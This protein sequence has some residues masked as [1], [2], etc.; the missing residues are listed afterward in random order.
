MVLREM[1]AI[2][3]ISTL[4]Y[5]K[6]SGKRQLSPVSTASARNRHSA[7]E[8]RV[9]CAAAAVR[10]RGSG[11]DFLREPVEVFEL[12]IERSAER[13]LRKSPDRGRDSASRPLSAAR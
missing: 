11:D 7:A 3:L 4:G 2:V 5:T 6:R 12:H 9:Y 13:G 1:A 10:V 8:P